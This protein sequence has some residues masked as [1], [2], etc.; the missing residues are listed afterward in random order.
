[1]K[2]RHRIFA[3]EYLALCQILQ[4]MGVVYDLTHRSVV[5]GS[6]ASVRYEID[7]RITYTAG[8]FLERIQGN[9]S[10]GCRQ[11]SALRVEAKPS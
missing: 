7:E 6:V 4:A 10:E 5:S 11:R 2:I 1:M 9:I 8:L 3:P